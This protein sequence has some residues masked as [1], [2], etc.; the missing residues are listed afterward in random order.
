MALGFYF[1]PSGFT[2]DNYDEAIRQLDAAGAGSPA[3]RS[4][5]VAL[6]GDDGTVQVFDIWESQEALDA[7]GPTLGPILGGLGVEPGQPTVQLVRNV[8]GGS[9]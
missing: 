8:I 9:A 4:L 5:H 2:R 1:T 7:F 3:G 6:E